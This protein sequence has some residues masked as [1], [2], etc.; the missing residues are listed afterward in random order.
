MI[1]EVR[2]YKTCHQIHFN[3]KGYK[4]YIFITQIGYNNVLI[5]EHDLFFTSDCCL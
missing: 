2:K 3:Y 1:S 4:T 5:K